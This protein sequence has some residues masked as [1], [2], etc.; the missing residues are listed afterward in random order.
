MSGLLSPLQ[1]PGDG[2]QSLGDIQDPA[3]RKAY[4]VKEYAGLNAP[5]TGPKYS[6]GKFKMID[7]KGTNMSSA[8]MR[9]LN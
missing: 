2:V 1:F 8:I 3:W 5:R 9:G 6:M 4:G 7:Q